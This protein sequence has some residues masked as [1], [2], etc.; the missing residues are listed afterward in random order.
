MYELGKGV[1]KDYS[2]A[3][4]WYRKAAEQGDV[5]GEFCLGD[6]YENGKGVETNLAKA[7]E[8]YRKAAAKG[9][10]SAKKRLASLADEIDITTSGAET[11][12]REGLE[13]LGIDVEGK[14]RYG[15]TVRVTPGDNLPDIL[16][17]CEDKTTILLAP[18][19]YNGNGSVRMYSKSVR[20]RGEGD[21]VVL[22]KM[23]FYL[24][25]NGEARSLLVVENLTLID[26]D[27]DYGVWV[28]GK[29]RC[30]VDRCVLKNCGLWVG[31][32]SNSGASCISVTRS[33]IE[34]YSLRGVTC[35]NATRLYMADTTIL[36]SDMGGNPVIAHDNSRF[37]IRNSLIK[38]V[39]KSVEGIYAPYTGVLFCI[40]NTTFKGLR[41]GINTGKDSMGSVIRCKFKDM[42]ECAIDNFGQ[43]QTYLNTFP[44]TEKKF[45]KDSAVHESS[46]SITANKNML[47]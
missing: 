8:L 7:R 27:D 15:P 32:N 5:N 30:V 22:K 24:D 46:S 37:V 13:M 23:R 26:G 35:Y 6:M 12:Y 47:R 28:E 3:V 45:S 21:G 17:N 18:G 36:S 40:E 43:V 41:Y 44:G 25:G 10:D 4:K 9:H 38:S 16:K 33:R 34:R 39:G 29:A 14:F 2:E 31:N 19:E 20:I 1:A 42:L 11:R